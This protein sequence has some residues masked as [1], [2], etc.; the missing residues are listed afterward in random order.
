M[1]ADGFC[2][3][4]GS[5]CQGLC[6]MNPVSCTTVIEY[7]AMHDASYAMYTAGCYV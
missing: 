5:Q 3:F 7:I 6:V 2:V 4:P 1:I